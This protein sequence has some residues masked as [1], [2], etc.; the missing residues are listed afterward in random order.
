MKKI[1][2]DSKYIQE[3]LILFFDDWLVQS[4]GYL[5][6]GLKDISEKLIKL[7]EGQHSF[8]YAIS[9]ELCIKIPKRLKGFSNNLNMKK[10]YEKIKGKECIVKLPKVYDFALDGS[11]LIIERIYEFENAIIPAY[12]VL[13][14]IDV[15]GGNAGFNEEGKLVITDP[16]FLSYDW[17][18]SKSN[19]FSKKVKDSIY[20]GK[21]K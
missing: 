3:P 2:V 8:V 17:F 1:I 5:E 13:P 20:F 16:E 18:L 21:Q 9:D 4:E 6:Y 10:I 12:N 11:W 15:A 14:T 7:G 19:P